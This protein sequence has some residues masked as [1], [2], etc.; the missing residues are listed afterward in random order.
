MKQSTHR[1]VILTVLTYIIPLLVYASSLIIGFP[2]KVGFLSDLRG[3][4]GVPT[5]IVVVLCLYLAYRCSGRFGLCVSL[6]IT[7]LL[8][9]MP[10]SGLWSNGTTDLFVIG[11]LIPHS[12]ASNYYGEARRLLEGKIFSEFASNRPLF[13]GFLAVLLGLTQQNLQLTLSI[14]VAIASISCFFFAQE[15]KRSHGV[16]AAVLSLILLFLFYRPLIGQTVTENLGL[17]LGTLGFA[18]FWRGLGQKQLSFCFLGTFLLTLG[19]LARAGAFFVL[20][21]IVVW[22][23]IFFQA[24]TKLLRQFLAGSAGLIVSGFLINSIFMRIIG[25]PDGVPFSNFSY[26]LYGLIVGGNW[27]T[28]F[29][30]HGDK[31]TGS[32]AENSRKIY[33]LAFQ[34]FK[35][36][37]T[38][39]FR[40]MLRAWKEYLLM[41]DIL[42]F[43]TFTFTFIENF[44]I[45]TIVGILSLIG[46]LF[47]IFRIRQ[48]YY[49]SLI[50]MTIGIFLSIPFIPPWDGGIRVHAATIPILILLPSIGLTSILNFLKLLVPRPLKFLSKKSIFKKFNSELTRNKTS[51]LFLGFLRTSMRSGIQQRLDLTAHPLS[52]NMALM[53][54]VVSL[55]AF[56]CFSP[57]LLRLIIRPP[58]YSEITC[59][60]DNISVYFRASSGSSIGIVDNSTLSQTRVPNIRFTDFTKGI[61]RLFGQTFPQEYSALKDLN[62]PIMIM[63]VL[64]IKS[65]S[66]LRLLARD[67]LLPKDGSIVGACVKQAKAGAQIQSFQRVSFD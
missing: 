21:A 16:L 42:K 6:S 61:S 10:L 23:V 15:I 62:P 53:V 20:P 26:V 66:N 57:I 24:S 4:I 1:Q 31:L 38:S 54:C 64:D 44:S 8:F 55:A 32:Y 49:S 39:L 12:D 7:L 50:A 58:I 5:L 14:L 11:G 52:Q 22:G 41:P 2:W 63:D 36:D 25:S 59:P 48:A 46:I 34:A 33:A 43:R 35:E 13:M 30:H 56:S 47:C 27:T 45:E 28:V 3:F 67:N 17:A 29:G 51:Q 40:G 37:P 19:L 9:A 18:S 60:S 65:G